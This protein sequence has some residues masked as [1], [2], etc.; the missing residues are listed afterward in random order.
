MNIINSHLSDVYP[1][2][3]APAHIPAK[4]KDVA[5]VLRIFLSHIIPHWKVFSNDCNKVH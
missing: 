4:Y 1:K 2:M 3:I 5:A